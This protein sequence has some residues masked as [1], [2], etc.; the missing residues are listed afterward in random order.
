MEPSNFNLSQS[1]DNYIGLIKRQGSLTNSDAIEL[2][3]HLYDATEALQ[4]NSLTEEEA[5]LIARKRLGHAEVL[6]Q[7]YGK[8]N[9]T[10]TMN[11][12][13][14]YLFL[15]F[16]LMYSIPAILLLVICSVYLGVYKFYAVSTISTVIVTLFHLL[17]TCLIWY[18][19]K[20]KNTISQFIE[21]QMNENIGRTVLLSFAP[22]LL[23]FFLMPK[24]IKFNI[25]QALTYPEYVFESSFIEFSQYF[26]IANLMLAI[27][28]LI[29]TINKNEGLSLKVAFEK[30]SIIALLCFGFVIE[31]LAASTRAMHIEFII[32]KAIIFGMVYFVSSFLIAFYNKGGKIDKY[33]FFFAILGVSLETIVGINAD[34]HRS[35]GN[36]LTV[37]FVSAMLICIIAGR[38][39]GAKIKRVGLLRAT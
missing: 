8:V 32:V 1:I 23:C 5:F 35:S 26:A 27:L 28:S 4:K 11:K 2:T 13:W 7:E 31:L 9:T 20:Q 14:A 29:F 21:K 33:I 22:M 30:P 15:G 38:L 36:H 24:L 10:V 25:Y 16:N 17:L 34:S 19:V 3:A 37:Y 6:T 18:V 39:L 12:T